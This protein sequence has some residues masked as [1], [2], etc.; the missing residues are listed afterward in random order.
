MFSTNKL[1]PSANLRPPNLKRISEASE[2]EE[3]RASH[4]NKKDAL[5]LIE[6]ET[7]G[8]DQNLDASDLLDLD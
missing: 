8:N 6:E 4:V 5:A 7:K 3:K 2:A 1:E